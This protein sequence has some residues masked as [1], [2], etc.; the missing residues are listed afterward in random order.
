MLVSPESDQ[1][2]ALLIG[3]VERGEMYAV[4]DTLIAATTKLVHAPTIYAALNSVL[5]DDEPVPD[6]VVVCQS[7]P[8]EFPP[9]QVDRLLGKLSASRVLCAHGVWC[10]GDGRTRDAWPIGLRVP[11]RRAAS[12]ILSELEVIRGDR[13]PIQ[14]TASR[15]EAFAFERSNNHDASRPTA[16]R[17]EVVS[18]DRSLSDFWTELLQHAGG[19]ATAIAP[20]VA[21]VDVDPWSDSVEN[22]ITSRIAAGTS[23]VAVGGALNADD[24][25]ALDRLGVSA[26]VAKLD[27]NRALVAAAFNGPT[28]DAE[29]S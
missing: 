10:A 7:W 16:R 27:V 8:E 28:P 19:T 25:E 21:L 23:V 20:E 1:V 6:L 2:I 14:P 24:A 9:D 18:P 3:D 29:L 4:G 5:A 11:A 15:D 12:R 13:I 26:S 22:E 17:F